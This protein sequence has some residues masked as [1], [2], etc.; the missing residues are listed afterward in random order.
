MSIDSLL[1]FQSWTDLK[2]N[3]IEVKEPPV[4]PEPIFVQPYPALFINTNV[5]LAPTA[6]DF[7][8]SSLISFCGGSAT[9]SNL[10]IPSGASLSAYILQD[11]TKYYVFTKKIYI[12][13]ATGTRTITTASDILNAFPVSTNSTWST[14]VTPLTVLPQ[15]GSLDLVFEWYPVL[16]KWCV[17]GLF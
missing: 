8:N 17:F 3:S 6:G 4:P 11:V 5:S 14:N 12:Y 7:F 10:S 1:S 9:P 13:A 2:V 15:Q 16:N